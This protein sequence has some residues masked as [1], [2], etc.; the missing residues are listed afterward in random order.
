MSSKPRLNIP[1]P[2]SLNTCLLDSTLSRKETPDLGVTKFHYLLS[3]ILG[4]GDDFGPHQ[5]EFLKGLTNRLYRGLFETNGISQCFSLCRF[6][7]LI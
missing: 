3:D 1:Q 2:R 5:P 7:H 6:R 4:R